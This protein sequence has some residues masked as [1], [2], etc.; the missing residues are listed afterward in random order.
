MA[1][2]VEEVIYQLYETMDFDDLIVWAELY[3]VEHSKVTEWLDDE[4][5]DNESA[6]RQKVS[7]AAIAV[8]EKGSK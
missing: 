3:K 2:T 7:D 5:P 6:L 1:K 4:W 8:F